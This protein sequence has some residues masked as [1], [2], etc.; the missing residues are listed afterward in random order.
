MLRENKLLESILRCEKE[1]ITP[2]SHSMLELS[3]LD[4]RFVSKKKL[5]Y[6]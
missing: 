3:R 2:S 5:I 6:V 1:L 4:L